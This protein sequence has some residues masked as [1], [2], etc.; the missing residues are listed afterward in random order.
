MGSGSGVDADP[1][2]AAAVASGSSGLSG[3]GI[4]AIVIALLLLLLLGLLL[5]L[6]WRRQ[7]GEEDAEKAKSIIVDATELQGRARGTPVVNPMFAPESSGASAR[8]Q[9]NRSSRKSDR[10][11]ARANRPPRPAHKGGK[12][13]AAA[14]PEPDQE[15]EFDHEFGVPKAEADA[16]ADDSSPPK[17][18]PWVPPAQDPLK[19]DRWVRWERP[20]PDP[21]LTDFKVTPGTRWRTAIRQV[22]ANVASTKAMA[23]AALSTK[24]SAPQ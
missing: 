22:R 7:S 16:P 2:T 17:I 20:P 24:G 21:N 4:A 8:R 18:R 1:G 10:A 19:I 14:G 13:R 11:G 15:L 3:G 23:T 12:Y 9:P 5:L 6:R